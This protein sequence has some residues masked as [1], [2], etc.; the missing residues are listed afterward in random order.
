MLSGS[1]IP[2]LISDADR[3][4]RYKYSSTSGKTSAWAYLSIILLVVLVYDL[5]LRIDDVLLAASIGS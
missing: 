1:R 5:V 3:N 4:I 2:S